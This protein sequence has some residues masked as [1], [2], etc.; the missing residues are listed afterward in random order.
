MSRG[1][2]LRQQHEH[3]DNDSAV[4]WKLSQYGGPIMVLY[5]ITGFVP[6][7]SH[8]VQAYIG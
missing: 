6:I 3:P 2:H 4:A 5:R 7:I 1:K 8:L